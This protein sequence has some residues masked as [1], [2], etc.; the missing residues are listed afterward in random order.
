[1]VCTSLERGLV[2]RRELAAVTAVSV[3]PFFFLEGP[4]FRRHLLE[5]QTHQR[6]RSCSTKLALPLSN[7]LW[8]RAKSG[9]WNG[10]GSG[11]GGIN[12]LFL[13]R[14]PVFSSSSAPGCRPVVAARVSPSSQSRDLLYMICIL[15]ERD[16]PAG[17]E[18]AAVTAVFVRR[19]LAFACA[20]E[21]SE[22][23]SRARNRGLS[24]AAPCSCSPRNRP[25]L[26]EGPALELTGQ[27]QGRSLP[28]RCKLLPQ[29]VVAPCM[30]SS[31][32]WAGSA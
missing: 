2:A 19:W 21:F 24:A 28:Q 10:A 27:Y 17:V 6:R 14:R 12:L 29:Q 1:M 8:L 23:P 26:A 13:S 9:G 15:P 22:R 7:I 30:R 18:L 5:P 3:C 11:D 4:S 20:T 16:L 31:R 32:G 25:S